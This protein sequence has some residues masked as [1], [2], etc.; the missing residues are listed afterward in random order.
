MLSLYKPGLASK[1]GISADE[2]V[3]TS[4]TLTLMSCHIAKFHA[5]LLVRNKS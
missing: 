1:Y 2:F 4:K 3:G 5:L